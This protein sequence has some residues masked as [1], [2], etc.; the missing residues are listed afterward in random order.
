MMQYFTAGESHGPCLTAIINNFPAGVPIDIERINIEL[1]K[2]QQGYGR[3]GRMKI[4]T[5]T[6][7]IL[8]GVRAGYSLGSPIT[9]VVKNRDYENWESIMNP[10]STDDDE[11]NETKRV[12]S[13]RPGHADLTGALKYHHQTDMR[14]ILERSSARETA[15][16]TAVGALC[17]QFLEAFDID[18]RCFVVQIGD[19]EL[20]SAASA[21]YDSMLD[22]Y[23][24]ELTKSDL[25]I[26]DLECKDDVIK[27]IDL[28]MKEKD[29]IGGRVRLLVKN[30][31]PALGSFTQYSEKLDG[32]LA[33]SF[34]GTQAIKEVRF[35]LG[36]T[37]SL[38]GSNFHD[39]IYYD[40]DASA[41]RRYSNRAGGIEGGM[42]N[43]EVLDVML[44]MKPIPTLMSPLRTVDLA[45]KKEVLAVKERS[46]VCAVPA[47]S[48]VIENIA[49]FDLMNAFLDKFGADQF[50][51]I[52][53]NYIR[54]Q[55]YLKNQ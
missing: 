47:L 19:V 22:T 48:V 53:L 41:Y 23:D 6:V 13:P 11:L 46:D 32:K 2:R 49:S 39:E 29:T 54:F 8:S 21:D 52:K 7:Q 50:D 14:N 44:T 55:E 43:G 30:L 51:E 36:C 37:G 12:S 45:T 42:T 33:A 5:D 34:M 28:M 27:H 3:G 9:L 18:L 38:R 20:P 26:L 15:V 25:R 40:A 4:E 31:P 35:G 24:K 16:R 10:V 1:G 17:R